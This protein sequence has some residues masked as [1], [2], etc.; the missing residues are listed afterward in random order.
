MRIELTTASEHETYAQPTAPTRHRRKML[1]INIYLNMS[2]PNPKT[3]TVYSYGFLVAS[4]QKKI[5][6][7]LCDIY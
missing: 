5:R 7:K 3:I 4:S 6:D 2:P 1:V